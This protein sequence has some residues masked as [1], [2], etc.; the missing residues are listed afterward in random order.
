MDV[1]VVK[2]GGE[3][4]AGPL[5]VDVA[6]LTAT[7]ARVVVVHGGAAAM[8]RLAGRLGVTLREIVSPDGVVTR[9]T[10]A[11]TLE[12]LTLALAGGVKP[13]LVV[14]LVR[15]GVRAVG[16]TGLDAGLVRAR[17]RSA[18]RATVDGRTVLLR[19][20][21]SG[22]ITGV[23]G[24]VLRTL[25]GAGLVPVVSPPVLADDDTPVNANA[26]RVAAAIAIALGARRLVFLTASGGVR[27]DPDDPDS[28]LAR[29]RLPAS[30]DRP[31]A[32]I[33]GGMRIKLVAAAEALAGGVASVSVGERL[34]PTVRGAG[35]VVRPALPPGPNGF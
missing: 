18:V 32:G 20:D 29:Y 25:L 23:D 19:G 1:T 26:D 22:R 27:A 3:V 10:D 7:G 35:T 28:V 2:I 34:L 11:A 21:H 9:R 15:H 17:R 6:A 8:A 16:L 31:G 12:V 33:G 30:G 13:A 5:G 4:P 14:E 24:V